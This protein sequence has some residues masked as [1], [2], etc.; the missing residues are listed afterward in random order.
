M[1]SMEVNLSLGVTTAYSW[2][3]QAQIFKVKHEVHPK[4][5]QRPGCNK[6]LCVTSKR[7]PL[8][9][10]SVYTNGCMRTLIFPHHLLYSEELWTLL[11]EFRKELL[12]R[13]GLFSSLRDKFQLDKK[14]IT[15]LKTIKLC[16][17][18]I[19]SLRLGKGGLFIL[20]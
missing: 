13:S 2:R 15:W 8:R 7:L 12:W 3:P 20:P 14:E 1:G 18:R 16:I 19:F 10:F 17:S 11:V 9:L 4:R 5:I 6:P